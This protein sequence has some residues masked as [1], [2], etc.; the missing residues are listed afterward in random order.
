MKSSFAR[1][2]GGSGVRK[3]WSLRIIAVVV[4]LLLLGGGTYAAL[5]STGANGAAA[6]ATPT[7][8]LAAITGGDQIVVE[9]SVVPLQSAE[10]TF[11]SSGIVD[12]VLVEEGDAVKKGDP[13]ARLDTR[14]LLLGVERAK[15]QISKATAA[16]DKL[17]EGATP[18]EIAAAQAQVDQAKG[19]LQ[20]T[21]GGVTGSDVEAAKANL[22]SA[23]SELAQLENGPR[24]SDVRAAKASLDSARIHL[25]EVQAG[26]KASE[27]EAARARL[28]QARVQLSDVE[29]GTKPEKI[30]AA[31]ARL[32]QA[33]EALSKAESGP[34]AADVQAAQAQL[35]QVRATVEDQNA[36]LSAAKTRAESQMRQSADD[37]RLAQ[38][39][40]SSAYWDDQQ[41]RDGRNPRTGHSFDDEGLDK[42]V[43]QRIYAEALRT[44]EL[45]LRQAEQSLEQAKLAY[46]SAQQAEVTGNTSGEAQLREAQANFDRVM[47]SIDAEVIAAARAQV[48][49]AEADLQGLTTIDQ[50]GLA[51]ARAELAQAQADLDKLTRIDPDQVASARAQ[52]ER[53]Q[54]DLDALLRVDPDDL[55]AARARVASAQAELDRLE[56]GEREGS[57]AAAAANVDNATAGLQQLTS[58]PGKSDLASALAEVEQ[59]KVA[60]KEAELAV[61]L[62]TLRAPIDGTVAEVNLKPGETPGTAEAAIVVADFSTWQIETTDLTEL[63]IVHIQE[64][65][66]ATL[67]FDA[68]PGIEMAATVT[69][70]KSIG[71]NS[72]GDITYT[73]LLKPDQQ[74][75]RLRWNMTAAV[76]ITPE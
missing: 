44:A 20:Q 57:V 13:L 3:K 29:A 4:V 60:L 2:P 46:E 56:G 17:V 71:K 61:D 37:L 35:D 25:R 10:L 42:E 66:P 8:D 7:P 45:Q 40:Y 32:D 63:S 64:G 65:S 33:R 76:I 43:Q 51:A 59:A 27:F 6:A 49:Q 11:Q 55:A 9:G 41:A 38:E 5:A 52:V 50:P 36:D 14:E 24:T 28:E 48:A 73:V 74:D 1:E 54:A 30:A 47:T 58:Q 39:A 62:A 23:Q 12:E 34:K 69:R 19:Q 16:Y 31:Q 70:I 15:V 21:E 18:E 67:T 75:A 22:A 72:Q 53:A 68:L 26:P